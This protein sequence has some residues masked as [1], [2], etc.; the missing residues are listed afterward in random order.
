MQA[1]EAFARR[2]KFQLHFLLSH[3]SQPTPADEASPA[4][5]RA[6]YFDGKLQD[7]CILSPRK[8]TGKHCDPSQHPQAHTT[9]GRPCHLYH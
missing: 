1:K 7:G 9:S 8:D 5:K 3:P 6:V 2:D 4:Q